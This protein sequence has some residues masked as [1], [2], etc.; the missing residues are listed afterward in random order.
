MEY[1]S[2]YRELYKDEAAD[3]EERY[4]LVSDRIKEISCNAECGEKYREYF[5]DLA[6]RLALADEIYRMQSDGALDS[7][8][9]AA[10]KALN[11][12]IYDVIKPGN[13]EKSFADPDV[14]AEKFGNGPGRMFSFI[15]A[16]SFRAIKDAFAGKKL[17]M[18]LF[19]E[20]AVEI[21][22][23]FC[24]ED[25]ADEDRILDIIKSHYHDYDE[26]FSEQYVSALTDPNYDFYTGIAVNS[27]LSDTA[28]LYRYG[29]YIDDTVAELARYINSL[30]EETVAAM[31]DTFTEGYRMGFELT[32]KDIT[33]KKLAELRY[34]IGFERV[35]RRA[36]A[37]F[38]KIGLS[39]IVMG[40]GI[41]AANGYG[42]SVNRQFDFDHKDDQALY[43]DNAYVGRSLECLENAFANV[44]EKACLY[45][46]PAVIES[47]GEKPFDPVNKPSAIHFDAALKEKRVRLR[48]GE[49]EII[50]RYI[51]GEEESFTIIS[52]PTPDIGD[53]FE[54][55]FDKTIEINTLDYMKYRE[56]QSAIINVLDKADHVR[57]K[58][59]GANR[60]D[61]TVNLFKLR[62]PAK[63][64]IFEN[65]VADVNIPVGEVFTSPVLK[66]TNGTLNVSKVY[67]N[68][69]LYKDLCL[70]FKDG[71][72]TSYSCKNFDKEKD[73]RTYIEDNVLF[74]HKTLPI[75]EFAIGTNTTA[76]RMARDF[77]I[78]DRL[79]ILIAEKTGPHFAV[80]D[81]CYSFSEDIV[82]YNPDGK[83]IVARDNEVTAEYRK[84]DRSKAYFNCHTDITIPYD[85]LEYICAVEPDGTEH[86]IIRDGLFVVPGCEELNIPLK[87]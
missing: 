72:I 4:T 82:V 60:T 86:D 28:Y 23:C 81:T 37:N 29:E 20:L 48:N 58:G 33:K 85:E 67:L 25:G 52:F 51:R 87:S 73:N 1:G 76:Y 45:G 18:T 43:L 68:G 62:D 13:Y 78:A 22:T 40:R 74:G 32:G 41:S 31:A 38:E 50:N 71:F 42:K 27:D 49:S 11:D 8:D 9:V 59:S 17:N 63:E 12:R 47:F 54:E 83:E 34:P 19:F 6:G 69:L 56:M 21:Y 3:V 46:G 26:I 55:I 24:D 44:K 36:V 84:T 64:T 35:V 70:E 61:I 57:V 65:C 15:Y 16:A 79:T 10:G 80:G 53:R 2:H 14:C 30:P 77:D 39:A 66:G 5:T 7:M 75:G